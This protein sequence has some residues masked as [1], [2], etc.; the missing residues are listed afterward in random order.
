MTDPL[1][2]IA[3]AIEEIEDDDSDDTLCASFH[4]AGRETPWI[5]VIPGTLNLWWP[6]NENPAGH[7]QRSGV[8]ILPGLTLVDWNAGTFAMF[9]FDEAPP[10][11]QA[12]VVDQLFR[13]LYEC[14]DGYE[15]TVEIY[16][17]TDEEIPDLIPITREEGY[18]THLIGHYAGGR[19]FMGFVVATIPSPLPKDWEQHKRW[20]AVLH[21]FDEHGQHAASDCWFAGTTADGEAEVTAR[22]EVRLQDMLDQLP[23]KRFEDI[24]VGLFCIEFDEHEFG[25]I[26][27]TYEDEETGEVFVQAQLVPNDLVFFPPWDGTYD[28]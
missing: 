17:T 15:L 14:P 4:I 8:A 3:A 6:S 13:N 18:H 20:Y 12:V 21:T 2:T 24:E 7:V 16:A 19:S 1:A 5:Q 22:A 26:D 28:T 9:E 10:E 23:D 25:L 11:E 27:T